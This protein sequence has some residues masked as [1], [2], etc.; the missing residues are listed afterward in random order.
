MHPVI[1]VGAGMSGIAAARALRAADL[2]VLVLDR[3]RRIGGR[4]AVRTTDERPVDTGA[5]YFT[6]SDP[7]FT[8]VVQDWERRGLARPWTD[9]FHVYDDG[10][11]TP[12]SGPVRWAAPRGLRALVEDLAEGL[13]IAEQQ[14]TRV[15]PGP[16][17]D[18]VPASAVVLAMPDPQAKR[19][20]DPAFGAETRAL[21]DPYAPVLVLTAVW[22]RRGWAEDVDGVFVSGDPAI[23]WIADDGRRRGDDA[24]VLVAHSTGELAAAHLAEPNAAEAPMLA[25]VQQVLGITAPPTSARVHR[26]TFAKPASTRTQP[27]FLGAAGLG[28]CCDAWSDKPRVE[29]AFLSG[30]RLGEALAATLASTAR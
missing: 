25:A 28:L 11:L 18:D 14:V 23:T 17:V 1:V 16:T 2:P 29:S 4:M 21:S 22:D 10:E 15:E 6:V 13:E 7:G 27:F 5:S 26:W 9:T 30:T 19:L 12:K 8:A 3:G 20:L 24:P